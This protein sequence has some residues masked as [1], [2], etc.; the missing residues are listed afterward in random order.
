[1][2]FAEIR[3]KLSGSVLVVTFRT[4]K[5]RVFIYNL[6]SHDHVVSEHRHLKSLAGF[7]M[8]AAEISR[9]EACTVDEVWDAL[10]AYCNTNQLTLVW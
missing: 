2:Q 7:A 3:Y 5:G 1:M 4:A 10:D 8:N 9:D 6:L